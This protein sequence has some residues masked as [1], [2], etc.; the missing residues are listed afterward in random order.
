LSKGALGI[1]L[2]IKRISHTWAYNLP[3]IDYKRSVEAIHDA[4]V[5]LHRE[6]ERRTQIYESHVDIN[7]EIPESVS[8]GPRIVVMIEEMNAT[9]DALAK[10]W[11]EIREKEDPKKSPALTAFFALTFMARAL[12]INLVSVAQSG[13][14]RAF[15]GSPE[16]RENFGIRCMARYSVQQWKML[17]RIWPMP[18]NSRIPGRWQIVA[19]DE[20]TEV[21]VA[22]VSPAELRDLAQRGIPEWRR[23]MEI[24]HTVSAP[25]PSHDHDNLGQRGETVLAEPV[26]TVSPADSSDSEDV[27][28]VVLDRPVVV[29]LREAVENG[30]AGDMRLQTLQRASTRDSEFPQPRGKRG[31]SNLY[32]VS[33]LRMWLGNRPKAIPTKIDKGSD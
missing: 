12:D 25:T 11:E 27:S 31:Q 32:S 3:N 24:D 20:A 9:S 26:E 16:G 29:S 19:A 33:E 13:T 30:I 6:L 23:S 18:K 2:D 8:V 5:R 15:G 14:V 28:D 4:L 21:Q 17:S 7:G 22:K 10:Y 1:V